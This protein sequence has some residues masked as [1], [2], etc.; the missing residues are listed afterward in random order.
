MEKQQ[1]KIKYDPKFSVAMRNEY[2]KSTLPTWLSHF[3]KLI[4]A[5]SSDSKQSSSYIINGH[6]TWVDYLLVAALDSSIEFGRFI[7]PGDYAD[8][9]KND[10]LK[11]FPKLKHYYQSIFNRPA[12]IDY[13]KS[14]KRYPYTL[15][16]VPK[17]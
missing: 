13:L 4:P 5:V 10:V 12:I 6:L 7:L 16:Y 11:N 3:E 15:P 17:K 14:D 2:L 1:S 8:H 9:A